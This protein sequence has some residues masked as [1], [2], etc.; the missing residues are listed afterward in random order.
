MG[1]RRRPCL[2]RRKSNSAA[3]CALAAAAC[4]GSSVVAQRTITTTA[5]AFTINARLVL[6]KSGL[7]GDH[8]LSLRFGTEMRPIRLVCRILYPFVRSP[9]QFH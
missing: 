3:G 4:L 2:K 8:V 5:A 9:V 1:R 6:V 7:S